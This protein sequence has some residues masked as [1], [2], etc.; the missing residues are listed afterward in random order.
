M[1]I[2]EAIEKLQDIQLKH[3]DIEVKHPIDWEIGFEKITDLE[4]WNEEDKIICYFT[5]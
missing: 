5:T 3:G 4:T 1:K 2:S